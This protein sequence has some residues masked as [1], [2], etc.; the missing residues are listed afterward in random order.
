VLDLFAGSGALGLEAISRGAAHVRFVES[1]GRVV[2]LL[3]ANIEALDV[4]SRSDIQVRDA[5][6]VV[7]GLPTGLERGWDI[8]LADPPYAS[9]H[10]STLVS[11]FAA[12]P[13]AGILCVEHPR[14]VRFELAPD[15]RRGYG[16][17]ALS[18]FH[19]PTEGAIDG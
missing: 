14:N 19:D 7:R 13:F 18:I 16:D 12:D 15:W 9:A 4:A 17:N 1:D 6:A 10:A 5:L 8:A 11:I 2:R 3:R